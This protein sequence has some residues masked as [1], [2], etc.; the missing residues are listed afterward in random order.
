[1]EDKIE[2]TIDSKY[3]IK[4]K[5]GSGG[6]SSVFIVTEINN[7]TEYVAKVLQ[8]KDDEEIIK[9]YNNEIKYLTELKQKNIP[10]IINIIDSG[11]GPIIRKNKND[12]KPEIK[13]YIVLE[14]A[15][16]RQLFDF[17]VYSGKGLGETY[18][19]A[20][21]YKIVKTIQAIHEV[22]ICHKDIKLENILLNENYT[23]KISDFG[24]ASN[25]SSKLEDYF[26]S[27]PYIPPEIIANVPFDGFKADIFS[28]G[29]TLMSLT[30]CVPGFIKAS[31]ECEFYKAI[32]DEREDKYWDLVEKLIEKDISEEFKDLFIQMV[33]NIPEN[34]P[35]IQD[36]LIHRWFNSYK[37]MNDEEK[38]NLEK[39][40]ISEFK[41]REEII[42]DEITNE[43]N[44]ANQNSENHDVN[45]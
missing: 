44:I 8:D 29:V 26:G 22:G 12:G 13:K 14:Y 5:L 32:I 34:R 10:N 16:N 27:I 3:I 30:F 6:T 17:I 1:M 19:K 31:S 39:E 7:N 45:R 35:S 41:N 25:N 21:F 9:Q 2:D 15:K 18:S 23:P 4:R 20:I 38:D 43:I 24:L 40:I 37:E 11:E 33:S 42:Q 28:L 36:I